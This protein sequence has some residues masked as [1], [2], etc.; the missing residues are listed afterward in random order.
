MSELTQSSDKNQEESHLDIQHLLDYI[1]N[2]SMLMADSDRDAVYKFLT[3]KSNL[4][5]LRSF[6]TRENMHNFCL[7]INEDESPEPDKEFLLEAEPT[8]KP[9]PSTNIIFIK[10]IPKLDCSD[11]KK[12]K[13]DL[14]ILN[15]NIEKNDSS[16]ISHIQNCIQSAF[17]SLFSSYKELMKGQKV[18][19][20]KSH[21]AEVLKNKVSELVE[22]INKTWKT[23]EISNI[24]LEFE[25]FFTEKMEKIKKE[26]GRDPTVEEMFE[27]LDDNQIR[28][29]RESI[30]KW[31]TDISKIIHMNRQIS[32]GNTL[33]EIEFWAD[34]VQILKNIKKQV[35]SKE[36]QMTLDL[37][38]KKSNDPI[39]NVFE[40]NTKTEDNIKLAN[41][42]NILLKDLGS[43][44]K[45]MY[46][47][48]SIDDLTNQIQ[49]IIELI[50]G[51]IKLSSYPL[52]RVISLIDCINEDMYSIIIKI[53]GP[54][55]MKGKYEEFHDIYKKCNYLFKNVWNTEYEKLKKEI[56]ELVKKRNEFST[57]VK[58]KFLHSDLK[59]RLKEIKKFRLENK[60][61]IEITR[62]L[63]KSNNP[64]KQEESQITKDIRAAYKLCSAIDVLDMTEKGNN[65]WINAKFEYNK[66]IEKIEGQISNSLSEQLSSAQ[67]VNE[68]FRIFEKFKIIIKRPRIQSSIQDYQRTLLDNVSKDLNNLKDKF[69]AGYE[70]SSAARLCSIRGIPPVSGEIIWNSQFEEQANLYKDKIANVLGD[71]WENTEEG[72]KLKNLIQFFSNI[73]AKNK[74]KYDNYYKSNLG[75][76]KSNNFNEI[77]KI[78]YL[79][80]NY[81]NYKLKVNF[82]DSL[83]E[84]KEMRLLKKMYNTK[85]SQNAKSKEYY[86]YALAI[87]DAFRTFNNC[88]QKI[89]NEP[90]INKLIAQEKNQIHRLIRDQIDITWSNDQKVKD[91]AQTLCYKVSEFEEKVTELVQ[92][93]NQIDSLL[94]QILKVPIQKE[95][96]S[97]SI[98]AIQSVINQ[99]TGSSKQYSNIEKWIK[100]IDNKLENNLMKRLEESL[101]IWKNEFLASKPLIDPVLIKEVIVHKISMEN[102]NII[103]QPSIFEAREYWYA[104]LHQT[105]NIILNNKRLYS[106]TA[107]NSSSQDI[108]KETTFRD[109]IP[110]I[111]SKILVGVYSALEKTFI[112]CEEYVQTWSS[113]QVLWQIDPQFI[114]NKLGDN[115]EK[116]QQIMDGLRK[117]RKTFDNDKNEKVFGALVIDYSSVQD[118]VNNKYDYWHKEIMNQFANMTNEGMI[119]FSKKILAAKVI[120]EKNSLESESADIVAFITE[121]SKVEN[122][123]NKWQKEMDKYKDS[124][125]ILK[126]QKFN[127]PQKY[128]KIDDL[129]KE[130]NNFLNILKEKSEIMKEKKPGAVARINAEGSTIN[131][132][133]QEL[134]EYWAKKKPDKAE[135]PS[136]ALEIL[137]EARSLIEDVN[138]SYVKNCKAKELL[139]M[140]YS[141]P[142]KLNS[143]LEEIKDLE[144]VWGELNKIFSKIDEKKRY[145]FRSSQ[146]G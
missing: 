106:R 129:E 142:N 5:F 28:K 88:C 9:Y 100:D 96:I 121:I 57:V 130:W 76:T 95:S 24:K 61:L 145:S 108:Y 94:Q 134:E 48:N 34:Y 27:G 138:T 85:K 65:A 60:E 66:V 13:K 11:I 2:L 131:Q 38:K 90:K 122:N 102:K 71:E 84:F 62:Q 87:Q 137:K 17:L 15:F 139:E 8:I 16:M 104:Q 82:N 73:S 19:A 79:D 112:S 140:E 35:E 101:E 41:S 6:S 93:I 63:S 83:V 105:I 39:T 126:K 55:I 69:T 75:N 54:N 46:N 127:F 111:D 53:I 115:M 67:N 43:P 52:S 144:D 29:L 26:K 97:E 59:N 89:Q 51:K 31:N 74:E 44:V 1:S 12:I 3:I 78:I 123:M 120:L 47:S 45:Q 141:D 58:N 99:V 22:S 14:Q 18:S 132:K 21:N 124:H 91:F 70:K 10:K 118:K 128:K 50:R 116:W 133:I 30:N 135:Y 136:E 103:L 64:N 125:L 68:Q 110:K 37:V 36:V 92:I 119:E 98:S 81:G 143:L 109:L 114:F 4:E 146:C 56:Q 7:V 40:K 107:D 20:L 23:T 113:Y 77:E 33:D 49:R 86:P 80:G 32:E 117:G 72:K 25:P 42:Y